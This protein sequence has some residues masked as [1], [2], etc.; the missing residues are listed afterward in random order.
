MDAVLAAQLSHRAL[1]LL[2]FLQDVQDLL[3][4]EAPSTDGAVPE[5]R[6]QGKKRDFFMFSSY[7]EGRTLDFLLD[8]FF[9]GIPLL[10]H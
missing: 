6:S 1:T 2:G 4:G 7:G 5:V 9:G 3:F 10:F 8:H